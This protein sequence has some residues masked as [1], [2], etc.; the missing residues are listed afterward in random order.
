[1]ARDPNAYS[2]SQPAVDKWI[3]DAVENE[4]LKP[5]PEIVDLYS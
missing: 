4:F 3:T 5:E 1:V 2:A